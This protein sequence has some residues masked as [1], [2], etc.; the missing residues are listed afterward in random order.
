MLIDRCGFKR[1][2]LFLTIDRTT[3][4]KREN[5]KIAIINIS[6]FPLELIAPQTIIGLQQSLEQFSRG[7][8]AKFSSETTY[9]IVISIVLNC[10]TV[11]K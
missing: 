1:R 10:V 7:K 4:C 8:H 2:K 3:P 9:K 11:I 5:E 6:S